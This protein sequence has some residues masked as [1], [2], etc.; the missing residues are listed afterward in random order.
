MMAFVL[1]S[2]VRFS[3]N[4]SND[5]KYYNKSEIRRSDFDVPHVNIAY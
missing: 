2:L 3:F 1:H 5:S 4:I